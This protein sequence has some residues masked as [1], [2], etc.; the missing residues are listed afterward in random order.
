MWDKSFD[1][2]HI[3]LVSDKRNWYY[4][5]DWEFE[6]DRDDECWKSESRLSDVMEHWTTHKQREIALASSLSS[7]AVIHFDSLN[8]KWN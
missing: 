5:S 8:R 7:I 1:F 3:L 6:L 2:I 4:V